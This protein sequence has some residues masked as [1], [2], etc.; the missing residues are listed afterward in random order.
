MP[1]TQTT[2][3]RFLAWWQQGLLAPFSGLHKLPIN[4]CVIDG[5]ICDSQ[6]QPLSESEKAALKS[7]KGVVL[8]VGS[9]LVMTKRV[10]EAH[11]GLPLP[12]V[13][14]EVLPFEPS[15][16]ISVW[17][18]EQ[19]HIFCALKSNLAT[20]QNIIESQGLQLLGYAFNEHFNSGKSEYLYALDDAQTSSPTI[21]KAWLLAVFILFAFLSASFAYLG[22]QADQRNALLSRKIGELAIKTEANQA[23]VSKAFSSLIQLRTANE[24]TELLTSL[25]NDL[26]KSTVVDQLILSDDELLIDAS[27]QSASQLQSELEGS[28]FFDGTEFVS[29]ISRSAGD[30]NERFRLQAVLRK[31]STGKQGIKRA[32]EREQKK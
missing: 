17:G 7:L 13:I 31:P 25:S 30:D 4:V 8:I 24:V 27:A 29:S 1:Q 18:S 26:T 21:H 6:A 2:F 5:A 12:S 9:E 10:G 15:E 3:S 20:T 32:Q 16:L 19:E 23:N 11:K 14:A 22:E 28:D